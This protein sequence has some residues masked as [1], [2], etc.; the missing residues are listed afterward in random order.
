MDNPVRIPCIKALSAGRA[1]LMG[2]APASLLC[3]HSFPDILDE[4]TGEGYQ[5]P[6]NERHSLDFR[7]YI[8]AEGSSTIPLTLNLRPEC[9]DGWRIVE[10]ADGLTWLEIGR[11]AGKVM[12]QV[13]CQHRLGHLDDLDV[14]LPFMCYVGLS[15]AQ[16]TEVFSV[17]NGKAKGLSPS[18]LDFNTAQLSEDLG[19]ERPEL[20]VAL[21]LNSDPASPWYRSLNLGGKPTLGLRRKASLR[22]M[23]Q[24][25]AEFLKQAPPAAAMDAEAVAQL[26][27]AFWQAVV[28]VL[29]D[30]WDNPRHHLVTKGVGLYALMN[31]A[32]DIVRE[33]HAAGRTC[34]KR[35]FAAALEDFLRDIDWSTTGPLKGF[36]GQGGVAAAGE[37]IRGVRARSHV[38]VVNG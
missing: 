11:D 27:T 13:D 31:L 20:F 19:H 33:T 37:Y 6:F 16:E 4:A 38:R 23:Q 26:V 30:A 24:A 35:A 3:R 17:I 12:A 29:P 25:V 22:M 7:R 5:R 32:A 2:S 14:A 1:V 10:G 15:R 34:D 18:L 28:L 8:Q 21:R 36:G 9:R